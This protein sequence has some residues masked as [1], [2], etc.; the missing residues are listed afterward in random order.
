MIA[1]SILVKPNSCHEQNKTE[2]N[3][4]LQKAKSWLTILFT[5]PTKRI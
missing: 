3:I 2:V 5:N 4:L 1:H